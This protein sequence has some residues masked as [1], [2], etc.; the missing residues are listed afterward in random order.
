MPAEKTISDAEILDQFGM[1]DDPVAT[2]TEIANEIN[3][4]LDLTKDTVNYRLNK[5][6]DQ[7]R[8]GRKKVGARAVAW[9]RRD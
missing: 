6:L 2:A 4:G 8:V 1:T 7:N 9:W 3:G 5:L